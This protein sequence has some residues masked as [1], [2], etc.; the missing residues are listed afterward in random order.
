MKVWGF[1]LSILSHFFLIFPE[2]V[3]IWSHYNQIISGASERP[4]LP[5]DPPLSHI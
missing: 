4:K 2:N 1:A 3:I 5:L